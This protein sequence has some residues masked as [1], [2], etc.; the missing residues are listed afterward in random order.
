MKSNPE[1][2]LKLKQCVTQG[3]IIPRNE[4]NQYLKVSYKGA[5]R[6]ISEKWNIKIYT[7]GSVVCNDTDTLKDLLNDNVKE[8]DKS[9]KLIE[10]DDSGW[11]SPISG[12]MVGVS[13]NNRVETDVVDVS[14]FQSRMYDKKEYLQ[15][16]TKKGLRLVEQV[17]KATPRTHR[18][19]ICTGYIN[20]LLK[21]VLRRRGY[22]VR[23]MEIKGLLQ[24]SLENLF[25]EHVKQLT[26]RDM[27]YDPK[28]MSKRDIASRYYQTVNWAR[29]N[30]PHLLK[31]GWESLRGI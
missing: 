15:E 3:L 5:G 26:G 12:C 13:D 29:K 4:N 16:Y 11:G 21:A 18:I 2:E 28:E 20:T 14:F 17:F 30:C 25:R 19:H 7:T 31:T 6:L 10:I 9:L 27:A 1:M 24:D 23:V 8:P 22:D